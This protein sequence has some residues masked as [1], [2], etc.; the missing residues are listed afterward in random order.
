VARVAVGILPSELSRQYPATTGYPLVFFGSVCRP[1]MHFNHHGKSI[2]MAKLVFKLRDVPEEEIDAVRRLLDEH[3]FEYY[4]THA[5]NWGISVAGIWVTDD[6]RHSEARKLIDAFQEEHAS[7]MRAVYQ[8]QCQSGEAETT[9][10]RFLQNP[11]R[12]ILYL[13][14]AGVIGYFTLAPFF[15]LG[16]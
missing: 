8:Q 4:E 7:Q 9:L 3:G 15:E 6:Q 14:F 13:L 5:G 11:L 16:K 12:F 2:F 1:Q 10:Q